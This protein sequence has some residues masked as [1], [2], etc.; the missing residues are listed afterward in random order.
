MSKKCGAIYPF[1][2]KSSWCAKRQNL[3]FYPIP[4]CPFP[5]QSMWDLWRTQ[6]QSDNFSSCSLAL[7]CHYHSTNSPYSIHPPPTLYNLSNQKRLLTNHFFPLSLN[8]PLPPPP[9]PIS[10][11]DISNERAV[12][13]TITSWPKLLVVFL[14]HF[15]RNTELPGPLSSEHL[16]SLNNEYP[17]VWFDGVGTLQTT[18]EAHTNGELQVP[19]YQVAP[20]AGRRFPLHRN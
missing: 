19:K 10:H 11:C 17:L 13:N 18:R 16:P 1:P 12:F 7:P 5:G 6:C 3:W 15:T 2:H 20:R 4:T 9:T 14:I 8:P